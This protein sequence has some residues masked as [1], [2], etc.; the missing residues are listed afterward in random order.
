MNNIVIYRVH[1]ISRY[2]VNIVIH[3]DYR[4]VSRMPDIS[5]SGISV[6]IMN[7]VI[8]HEYQHISWILRCIADIEI[9][10]E[11]GDVS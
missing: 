11:Y 8:Y 9:Y 7:I 6:Y 4:D 2:I 5:C 3:S 1:W 10:R